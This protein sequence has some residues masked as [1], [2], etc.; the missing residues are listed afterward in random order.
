MVTHAGFVITMHQFSSA[1]NT[2]CSSPWLWVQGLPNRRG[3]RSGQKLLSRQ[4]WE[5]PGTVRG[6][7]S[8][9][10]NAGLL[11][12]PS[13]T[14]DTQ[15]LSQQLLETPVHVIEQRIPTRTIVSKPVC[16]EVECLLLKTWTLMLSTLY[17]CILLKKKNSKTQG[18]LSYHWDWLRDDDRDQQTPWKRGKARNFAQVWVNLLFKHP[19][20]QYLF[21]QVV[22]SY[23]GSVF[24]F[25]L[26]LFH[27]ILSTQPKPMFY[28]H[29]WSSMKIRSLEVTFPSSSLA[30]PSS[31]YFPDRG[32]F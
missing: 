18:A 17:L 25:F 27:T 29:L 24:F 6:N 26:T 22:D 21:F 30:K 14:W 7:I 3:S 20:C 16:S 5:R 19:A 8:G 23:Q 31:H 1:G 9:N 4:G 32:F 13:T 15:L 2:L 11:S 28:A 10:S 12:G